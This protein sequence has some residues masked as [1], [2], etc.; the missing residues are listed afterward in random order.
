MNIFT[1][2]NSVDFFSNLLV[3]RLRLKTTDFNSLNDT[4]MQETWSE[5]FSGFEILELIKID[6]EKLKVL[7]NSLQLD[8]LTY[9]SRFLEEITK[10]TN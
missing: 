1:A 2:D 4:K 5:L 7:G 6:N 10:R 9:L 8:N 3:E